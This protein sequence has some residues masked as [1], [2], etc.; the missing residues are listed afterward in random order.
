MSE[1]KKVATKIVA[2]GK[3]K[4]NPEN[5]RVIKD[6]KFKKLV[7]SIKEF[8]Q[9]L[10]I[11]PIVVNSEMMVLGGNMRLKACKEAGMKKIAIIQANDL[12]PEQQKEFII[13][14]NASFGEWDWTDLNEN[15]NI[16]ELNDWGIDGD[17]FPKEEEE[18]K[19]IYTKKIDIPHYHPSEE[20][21]KLVELVSSEK[22][23]SFLRKIEELDVD[24]DLKQF[25]KFSAYRHLSF[26]YSKIADFYA[27]SDAKV[28]EIMEDMALV[29]IDFEDAIKNGYVRLSDE[30]SKQYL[31]EHGEK[32]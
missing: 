32:K 15:W 25:L 5:P 11:R 19:N 7:K 29:I 4:P 24:D 12:T 18:E 14:D 16:E 26:N 20:A 30:I 9:M 2:I 10:Q 22:A 13:K 8:P 3:V 27:H 28:Q 1:L 6:D 21:P 31:D 23:D 17:F